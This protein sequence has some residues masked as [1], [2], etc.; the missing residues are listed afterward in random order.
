[1]TELQ[2]RR[3]T[4][5]WHPTP[6][7]QRQSY[8]FAVEKL[9]C[10]TAAI[11]IVFNDVHMI[12]I[13]PDIVQNVDVGQKADTFGVVDTISYILSPN[14]G[15]DVLL[16]TVRS[17]EHFFFATRLAQQL[18][19]LVGGS[20][21]ASIPGGVDVTGTVDA[22][23]TGPVTVDASTPLPILPATGAVFSVVPANNSPFTVSP[24]TGS[25][26]TMTPS[27]G[28]VWVVSGPAGSPVVIQPNPLS[29]FQVIAQDPAGLIIQ[30]P[31]GL[32]VH[33]GPDSPLSVNLNGFWHYT[34]PSVVPTFRSVHF[35]ED[36]NTGVQ[37]PVLATAASGDFF[38]KVDAT[39]AAPKFLTPSP[40]MRFI[41]DGVTGYMPYSAVALNGMI[42]NLTM[43]S[44]YLTGN[45]NGLK[46]PGSVLPVAMAGSYAGPS[47]ATYYQN[48]MFELSDSNMVPIL[49]VHTGAGRIEEQ[50]EPVLF[51]KNESDSDVE[52]I[53]ST[54]PKSS[55]AQQQSGKKW[56]LWS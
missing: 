33:A 35:V 4:A 8:M 54:P 16:G 40:V 37:Y 47:N 25:M 41:F 3:L 44:G 20:I 22:N 34:S 45:L 14:S 38:A 28:A 1:M 30:A 13:Y 56:A 29:V 42:P 15:Y 5:V 2:Y 17:G 26:W 48:S 39:A 24:E 46:S 21:I 49:A 10:Q 50:K 19:T 23:I 51:L 36:A 6:S 53:G 12:A 52:D 9:S 43:P 32:N 55:G 11:F 7:A 27:A 18:E 31:A